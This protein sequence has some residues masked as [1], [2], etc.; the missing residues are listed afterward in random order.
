MTATTGRQTSSVVH[1]RR[2]Y[3]RE[4]LSVVVSMPHHRT[5]VADTPRLS[6]RSF[7]CRCNSS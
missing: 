1:L 5:D 6:E 3:D 2:G 4:D 7:R